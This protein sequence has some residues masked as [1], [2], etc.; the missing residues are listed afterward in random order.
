MKKFTTFQWLMLTIGG[1]SLA[2]AC[3]MLHLSKVTTLPDNV[4]TEISFPSNHELV[5]DEVALAFYGNFR[6]GNWSK[7]NTIFVSPKRMDQ[8]VASDQKIYLNYSLY[9]STAKVRLGIFYYWWHPDDHWAEGYVTPFQ[10]P[11]SNPWYHWEIVSTI[12]SKD[13]LTITYS[14]NRG[15]AATK[16]ITQWAML[17][18]FFLPFVCLFFL[19]LSLHCV[20]KKNLHTDKETPT[21]IA[22]C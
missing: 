13:A 9:N 12:A 8:A 1:F 15:N 14:P 5:P 17:L 18:F 3:W 16:T 10:Y 4:V 19:V 6:S 2:I 7:R 20:K 21:K 22:P 11:P